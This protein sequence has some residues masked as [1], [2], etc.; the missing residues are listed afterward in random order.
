MSLL[1]ISCHKSVHD[2]TLSEEKPKVE[3][4]IR[5]SIGWVKTKDINLLHS[6][7]KAGTHDHLWPAQI[8]H[9]RPEISACL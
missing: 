8:D 6:V 9:F 1:Q 4:A 3:K 5:N 2:L 7:G